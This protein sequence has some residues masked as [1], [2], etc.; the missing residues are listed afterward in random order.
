LKIR[1]RGLL[2]SQRLREREKMNSAGSTRLK[3]GVN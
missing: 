1:L 2:I 3:R